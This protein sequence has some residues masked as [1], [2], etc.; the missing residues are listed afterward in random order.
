VPWVLSALR[1]TG[2]MV[3]RTDQSGDVT[4]RFDPRGLLVES[5]R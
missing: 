3:L 4:V 5:A 2:A 1:R